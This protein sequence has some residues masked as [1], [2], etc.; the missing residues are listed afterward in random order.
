MS[1]ERY[2]EWLERLEIPIEE[3]ATIEALQ[4]Y[5]EQEMV[6]SPEQIAALFSATEFKYE[7]L[8]AE[9]IRPVYITYPWGKELRFGVK[10]HPG[11]WGY[12]SV[13]GFLAEDGEQ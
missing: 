9:G 13:L 4:V 1:E 3:S 10:G 8:A 6:P 11:L 12:E 5:L 2:I 7:V